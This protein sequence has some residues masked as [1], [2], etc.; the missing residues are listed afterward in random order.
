MTTFGN[1]Q[2]DK[3]GIF[4]KPYSR[5]VVHQASRFG[6]VLGKLRTYESGNHDDNY[7]IDRKEDL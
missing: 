6:H 2:D 1:L 7:D 3:M 4:R 5:P